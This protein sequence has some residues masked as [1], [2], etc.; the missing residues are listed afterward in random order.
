MKVAIEQDTKYSDRFTQCH[1]N[2]GDRIALSSANNCQVLNVSSQ[3]LT[4]IIST[5]AR[6]IWT[7]LT[8]ARLESACRCILRTES[9]R[10]PTMQVTDR[11]APWW[12]FPSPRASAHQLQS[13]LPNPA[14]CQ[15][16]LLTEHQDSI[17]IESSHSNAHH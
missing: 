9:D 2:I 16:N 14:K 11:Q 8:P 3:K 10:Q 1:I 5:T 13:Y 12:C 17:F 4:D 15:H 6:L 7:P